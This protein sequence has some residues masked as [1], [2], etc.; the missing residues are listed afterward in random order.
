VVVRIL[1]CDKD[2]VKVACKAA[3]LESVVEQVELR[4]EAGFGETSGGV[5]IFSD[6][7]RDLELA[8]DQEWLVAELLRES[9][10]INQQH[11]AGVPTVAARE[12]VKLDAASLEQLAEQQNEG[13]FSRTSG[14]EIANADDRPFEAPGAEDAAAIKRVARA[15]NASVDG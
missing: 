13:S 6:D 14:G 10:G 7:H 5:A 11:A 3:M 2:D 12:N 15:D 1:G 4:A 9:G 8:G